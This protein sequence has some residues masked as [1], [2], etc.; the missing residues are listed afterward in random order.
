MKRLFCFFAALLV[1]CSCV[2]SLAES[3]EYV[4]SHYS[5]FIDTH[6]VPTA[7]GSLFDFDL[8]SVDLYFL[9]SMSG[10]YISITKS[11]DGILISPGLQKIS[12]AD[13][14]GIL[15]LAYEN[16]DY[17]TGS[18]D[19]DGDGIWMNIENYTFR[20]RPVPLFSVYDDWK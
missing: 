5:L 4:T 8:L 13:R 18:Y 12:V 20:L 14:D 2:P 19:E 10:G 6:S 17:L 11:F 1:L 3:F 15:Y 7:N 9:G 16:G